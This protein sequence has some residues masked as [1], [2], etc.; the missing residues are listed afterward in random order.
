MQRP[1]VT[2]TSYEAAVKVLIDVRT[3]AGLSQRELAE[4][5]GKP[6]SFVSKL[7]SRERR[8]DVV[9]MIAYAKALGIAPA[10]LIDRIASVLDEPIIF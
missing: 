1:W 5:L 10:D 6:R 4:L 3:E 8:L 9:E 7:E 2:S